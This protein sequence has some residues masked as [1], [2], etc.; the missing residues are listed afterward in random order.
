MYIAAVEDEKYKRQKI[1]FWDKVY[2]VD[3]SC[4]KKW[5]ITEPLIDNFDKKGII[6]D[7]CCF[8]V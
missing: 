4:M 3:M 1:N 8:Q 7:Y 5:V 2:G 6:S